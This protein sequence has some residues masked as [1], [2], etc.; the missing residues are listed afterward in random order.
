MF[1]GLVQFSGHA[2]LPA[3]QRLQRMAQAT[4]LKGKR[5]TLQPH[6]R[7]PKPGCRLGT[8]QRSCCH[9][10]EPME[11]PA[12]RPPRECPLSCQA[13]R[14]NRNNDKTRIAGLVRHGSSINESALFLGHRCRNRGRLAIGIVNL[15]PLLLALT[16]LTRVGSLQTDKALNFCR[17]SLNNDYCTTSAHVRIEHLYPVCRVTN[18]NSHLDIVH[19]DVALLGLR[20]SG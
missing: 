10:A 17:S 2:A 4:N 13:A 8:A 19:S 15:T 1:V 5:N 3:A 20:N 14:G 6:L 12:P 18:G 7:A 11:K 16:Y 9:E